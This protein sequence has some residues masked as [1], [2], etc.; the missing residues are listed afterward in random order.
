MAGR[1]SP[2]S[3]GNNFFGDDT[4]SEH[5]QTVSALEGNPE[6]NCEADRND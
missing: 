4:S 5:G 6:T 2:I 1:Y 3:V